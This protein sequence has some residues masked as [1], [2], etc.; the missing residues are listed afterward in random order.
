MP[1]WSDGDDD[2][3]DDDDEHAGEHR[4]AGFTETSRFAVADGG[5]RY[6]DGDVA[7]SLEPAAEP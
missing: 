1:R 7:S 4:P 5:W 2:D 6:L 3:D